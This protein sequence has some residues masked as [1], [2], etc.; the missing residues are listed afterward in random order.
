MKKITIKG[1]V[2]GV[3]FRKFIFDNAISLGLKGYVK[4]LDNGG[5]EVVVSGNENDIS[6]DIFIKIY[7]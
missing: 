6:A 7:K 4:N 3:F 5:V 1:Y 2:Q